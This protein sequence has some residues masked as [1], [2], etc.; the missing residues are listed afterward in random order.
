M[1]TVNPRHRPTASECLAHPWCQLYA[2]PRAQ[3][4]RPLSLAQVRPEGGGWARNPPRLVKILV[5]YWSNTGQILVGWAR[6]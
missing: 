3:P 6:A 4:A 1:M 2:G 5:K